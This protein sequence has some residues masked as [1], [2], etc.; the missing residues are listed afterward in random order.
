MKHLAVIAL[1]EEFVFFDHSKAFSHFNR[2][3]IIDFYDR[4]YLISI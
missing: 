1:G 3:Q 2:W 4:K